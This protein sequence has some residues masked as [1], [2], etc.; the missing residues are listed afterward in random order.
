MK[1]NKE[2]DMEQLY[3]IL[4]VLVDLEHPL[5]CENGTSLKFLF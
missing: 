4:L 1:Q 3:I 5:P 2:V